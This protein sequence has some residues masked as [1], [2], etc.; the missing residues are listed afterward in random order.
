FRARPAL[1]T[2]PPRSLRAPLTRLGSPAGT[3]PQSAQAQPPA[4]ITTFSLQVRMVGCLSA[5]Q[6]LTARLPLGLVRHRWSAP[7]LPGRSRWAVNRSDATRMRSSHSACL[8]T[9]PTASRGRRAGKLAAPIRGA[10]GR[11]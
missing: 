9:S 3:Y 10:R 4:N 2:G 5:A 6:Q 8:D 7:P 1:L 11:G